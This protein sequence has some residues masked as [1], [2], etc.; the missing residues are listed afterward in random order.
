VEFDT[1]AYD[2][3]VYKLCT[4]YCFLVNQHKRADDAS[5]ETTS[6]IFNE[7]RIHT[8]EKIFS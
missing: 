8:W 6:D 5:L 7:H 1:E 2:K 3:Y 4:E